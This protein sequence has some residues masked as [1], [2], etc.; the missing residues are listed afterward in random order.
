M[1]Q[2]ASQ[3]GHAADLVRERAEGAHRFGIVVGADGR[4]VDR[5]PDVDRGGVGVDGR[6]RLPWAGSLRVSHV[7]LLS[8]EEGLGC[9]TEAIS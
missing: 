8:D 7:V 4:D 6:Q 5:R 1:P 3:S 9:A 2:A